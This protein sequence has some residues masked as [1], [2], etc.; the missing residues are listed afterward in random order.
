M[1]QAPKT[2]R[3]S[4]VRNGPDF[5]KIKGPKRI[6]VR[7]PLWPLDALGRAIFTLGFISGATNA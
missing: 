4:G 5:N 2:T 7:V 6:T 1:K 3:S